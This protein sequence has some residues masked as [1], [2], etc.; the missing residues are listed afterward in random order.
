MDDSGEKTPLKL[1]EG[2]NL[3][4]IRLGVNLEL[5]MGGT[6]RI[7][8]VIFLLFMFSLLKRE[9]RYMRMVSTIGSRPFPSQ[10][11]EKKGKKD[12]FKDC[13]QHD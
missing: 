8:L 13:A 6:K 5:H 1:S 4:A 9:K 3:D 7:H 10:K 12:I 11:R 2:L